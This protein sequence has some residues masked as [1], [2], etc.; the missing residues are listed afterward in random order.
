MRRISVAA[1][2]P[3]PVA[4]AAAPTRERVVLTAGDA[5]AVA[6]APMVVDE[7]AAVRESRGLQ[8]VLRAAAL[9]GPGHVLAFAA[10]GAPGVIEERVIAHLH[11]RAG[12]AAPHDE[13]RTACAGRWRASGR[14]GVTALGSPVSDRRRTRLGPSVPRETVMAHIGIGGKKIHYVWIA[15]GVIVL[16]AIA[17]GWAGGA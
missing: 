5:I 8:P 7:L 13:P 6:V 2:D 17:Y 4:I 12:S 11:A 15:L 10:G 16:L 1:R 14:G 9:V 3:V